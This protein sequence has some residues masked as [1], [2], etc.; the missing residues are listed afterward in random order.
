[1]SL[2][3]LG[4]DLILASHLS[5]ELLDLLYVGILDGLG[6]AAVVED[7]VTVLKEVLQP[8]V[9]LVGV[10]VVLIAEIRHRD[11]LDQLLLENGNLLAAGKVT[12]LLLH[13]IPP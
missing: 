7:D 5:F 4:H 2:H 9:K 8:A 12:T 13:E 11:L 10:E 6:L 1:M 3:Q